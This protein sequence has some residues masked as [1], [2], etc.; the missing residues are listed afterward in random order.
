MKKRTY[1]FLAI[2]IFFIGVSPLIAGNWQSVTIKN[3]RVIYHLYQKKLA[4]EVAE[5]ILK[6]EPKY[7]SVFG[8]MPKDTIRVILADRRSEFDKLT[9]NT[10]PEWSR[11]VTR[12]DIH[13]IIL[14]TDQIKQNEFF[15][16]VRHELVHAWMGSL[17]PG[18][19]TPRWFDEGMAVLLSGE[20]VS[21]N[22]TIIS[23]AVLTGSLFSLDDVSQV[24]KFGRTK[25]RL[26]YAE[27]YTAMRFFV[28]Y[29][30]WKKFPVLFATLKQTRSFKKAVEAA[31]GLSLYEFEDTFLDYAKKNYRWQFLFDIDLYL[32]LALPV[33]VAV[34]FWW[35]KRRNRK[36]VDAW[37]EPPEADGE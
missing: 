37:Q 1:I 5:T 27:S 13:L 17:Y 20:R 6:T 9:K 25:A 24:L 33:F 18:I 19:Q 3:Y 2:L 21:D 7:K 8:E 26:A 32:W 30:G 29:F 14:L 16:V 4:E 11:G 12:P 36:R 15:S 35:I 22:T 28:K 10:I 34:S 31:T 23:R